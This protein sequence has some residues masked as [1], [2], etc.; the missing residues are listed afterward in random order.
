MTSVHAVEAGLEP[1]VQS[2]LLRCVFGNPFQPV[3]LDPQWLTSTVTALAAGIY[4]DRAFDRL[5]ILAD[6]LQDAGCDCELL[7]S[8]CRELGQH[9]RGCWV[10]DI[11]L[12]KE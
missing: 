8:H 12:E 11:L 7:L 2:A 9:C 6:A 4:A 3:K 1:A 5:P 10:V